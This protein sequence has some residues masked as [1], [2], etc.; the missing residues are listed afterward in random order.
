MQAQFRFLCATVGLHL[1]SLV[2]G[3]GKYWEYQPTPGGENPYGSNFESLG[4]LVGNISR[5][6]FDLIDGNRTRWQ[7]QQPPG[8][9][10]LALWR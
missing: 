6:Q 1:D 10:I 7:D 5:F 8:N 4:H 3:E 9:I 2:R